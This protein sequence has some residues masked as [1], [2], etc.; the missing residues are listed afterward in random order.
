MAEAQG[1]RAGQRVFP[2]Y[3]AGLQ[4]WP[5]RVLRV[6]QPRAAGR[7]TKATVATW[8]LALEAR[9]LG[10]V[11]I[12]VRITAVRKLA[13]EAADNG[14][15]APELASGITRV[16]GVASKGELALAEAGSRASPEFGSIISEMT[17]TIS[18]A[19]PVI[20]PRVC[21]SSLSQRLSGAPV[22]NQADPLSA[23]IIPYF[24]RAA[25]MIRLAREARNIEIRAK[26]DAQAHRRIL[27]IHETGGI[28]ARRPNVRPLGL[29]RR[30]SHGMADLTGE[31]FVVPHEAR[32]DRQAGCICRGPWRGTQTV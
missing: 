27:G 13:I 25:R 20:V 9:G 6:A 11:S 32:H 22:I 15:L 21:R 12:N 4:S 1:S 16:K 23:S 26:S 3:E 24:F 31:N 2:D 30:K 19:D 17:S 28:M 5:G 8:R 14:L 18:K 29:R 7:V 10:A